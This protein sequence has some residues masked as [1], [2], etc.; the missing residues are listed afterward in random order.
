MT[1]LTPSSSSAPNEYKRKTILSPHNQHTFIGLRG[2]SKQGRVREE[3]KLPPG[4][5]GSEE[6]KK[7]KEWEKERNEDRN[8]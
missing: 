5:G 3:V 4:V 8:I 2:W 6:R 7:Q 1:L